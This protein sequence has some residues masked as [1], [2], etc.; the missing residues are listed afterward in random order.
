M[1]PKISQT[2]HPSLETILGENINLERSRIPFGSISIEFFKHNQI[3]LNV[4]IN[5]PSLCVYHCQTIPVEICLFTSISMSTLNVSLSDKIFISVRRKL[6]GFLWMISQNCMFRYE[7]F[8]RG[9]SY[10][11]LQRHKKRGCC[12]T[13]TY[14]SQFS[15][16]NSFL[17]QSFLS[18]LM[19]KNLI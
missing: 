6:F 17:W 2:L 10:H 14:E 13:R 7:N 18:L 9:S 3:P 19:I 12:T 11:G 4:A 15:M 1:K 8:Y 5:S 16:I